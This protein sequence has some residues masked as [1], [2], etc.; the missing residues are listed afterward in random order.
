MDNVLPSQC[1]QTTRTQTS[2]YFDRHG[3]EGSPVVLDQVGTTGSLPHEIESLAK[4][5]PV[6]RTSHIASLDPQLVDGVLRVGG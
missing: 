1:A 6:P 5:R 3:A 4:G 2:W